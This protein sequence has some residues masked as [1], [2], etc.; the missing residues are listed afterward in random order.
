MRAFRCAALLL[1]TIPCAAAW[2]HDPG[3]PHAEWFRGLTVPGTGESC[4]DE[5]DCHAVEF[6]VTAKGYEVLHLGFWLPVP[7]GAVV[8]RK[9]NPIG[10]AVAC[11][12]AGDIG[13]K[14]VCFV[15]SPET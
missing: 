13:W 5:R 9:D 12:R 11:I 7:D 3:H 10:A 15:P 8:R 2:A 4:C 6:R 1:G 14:V